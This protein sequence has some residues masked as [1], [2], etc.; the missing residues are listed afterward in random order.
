MYVSNKIVKNWKCHIALRKQDINLN[1]EFD[2]PK[3]ILHET[4]TVEEL[5]ILLMEISI[6]IYTKDSFRAQS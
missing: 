6:P 2:A 4:N 5:N 3:K 1:S